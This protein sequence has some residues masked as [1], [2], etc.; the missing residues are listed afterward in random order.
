MASS[1]RLIRYCRTWKVSRRRWPGPPRG[2]PT[3]CPD[4]RR[5]PGRS[6]A[7]GPGRVSPGV[8]G[9]AAAAVATRLSW[10]GTATGFEF[11]SDQKHDFE[12]RVGS[13]RK[14][15]VP[16]SAGGDGGGLSGHLAPSRPT[17]TETPISCS[18][19]ADSVLRPEALPAEGSSLAQS[20][21]A[22]RSPAGEGKRMK[23]LGTTIRS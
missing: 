20:L 19:S 4:S 17:T 12:H 18:R 8:G 2:K 14:K 23:Q 9:T 1:C 22:G 3:Q 15:A 10:P 5:A 21:S 16:R 11:N 13:E 6:C 7:G